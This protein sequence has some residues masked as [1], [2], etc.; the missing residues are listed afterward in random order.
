MRIGLLAGCLAV[1]ALLNTPATAEEGSPSQGTWGGGRSAGPKGPPA[2]TAFATAPELEVCLE[3]AYPQGKPNARAAIE[4]LRA[5][6]AIARSRN[7]G[8]L[9]N[10]RKHIKHLVK[11]AWDALDGNNQCKDLANPDELN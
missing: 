3:E 7:H 2:L 10:Q 4:K 1:F 8:G 5:E 6:E 11:D 9:G